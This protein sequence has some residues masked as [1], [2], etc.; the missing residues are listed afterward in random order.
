M[1]LTPLPEV[2]ERFR[3]GGFVA[4]LDRPDREGEADL[5][6]AAQFATGEKINFMLTH[7]RGLLTLAIIAERLRELDIRIIEPRYCGN[8]VPAFTEPVDYTPAV[9]TGVSAFERA[10]TIQAIID[11]TTRAQDFMRPGH[12]FPLA[13]NAGGLRKR[14]GHT[15]G[16]IALA[17]MCDLY[18]AVCMCEVMT[19][20]GHMARGEQIAEFAARMGVALASTD[21][22][23]DALDAAGS[24]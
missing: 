6:L 11:P 19:P 20:E 21:Q 23:L 9:T 3:T 7:A 1:Q 18:P 16:A 2:L 12:V 5:L 17:K 24:D 14:G 22:L 15:E 13:A 4:L 8:N 10:A